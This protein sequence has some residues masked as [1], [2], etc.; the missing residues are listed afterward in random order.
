[1]SRQPTRPPAPP[2]RGPRHDA[3]EAFLG[4][5]RAEGES[6]GGPGQ[7]ETN[8]RGSPSRWHSTHTTRWHTGGFFLVQDER[9][10]VDGP[11]DTLSLIGWDDAADGYVARTFDNHGFYRHYDV[12]VDGNV[13]TIDGATERARIA[14]DDDGRR[15]VITWEWR[16]RDRWLPLCDRIATRT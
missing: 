8:P 11:F 16:P 9:A 5:W 2:A 1:M 10:L 6:F 4:D 14:F 13:W 7:D 15:Q 12:A 3:L